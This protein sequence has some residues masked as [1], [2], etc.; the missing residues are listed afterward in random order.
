MWPAAE[1]LEARVAAARVSLLVG[2]ARR[3]TSLAWN[4]TGSVLASGSADGTIRL[5]SMEPSGVVRRGG[6]VG[7]VCEALAHGS[8]RR[9]VTTHVCV[10][11]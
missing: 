3:V 2:H 7:V 10:G 1:G 6:S 5:W 9:C 4:A 8:A 11:V